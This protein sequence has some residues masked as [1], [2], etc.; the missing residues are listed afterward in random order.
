MS[1]ILNLISLKKEIYRILL[2]L[3]KDI[4]F[5]I[6]IYISFILNKSFKLNSYKIYIIL[7][8]LLFF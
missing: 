5:I 3:I 2:F 7:I 4:F 8:L 6:Y 1:F